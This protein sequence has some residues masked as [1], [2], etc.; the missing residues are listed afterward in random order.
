[1]VRQNLVAWANG[2]QLACQT[3]IDALLAQKLEE[4]LKPAKPSVREQ[5]L[6]GVFG[7]VGSQLVKGLVTL[8]EPSAAQ[9]AVIDAVRQVAATAGATRNRRASCVLMI[10]R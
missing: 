2:G 4:R 5:V 1:M 8:G 9:R 3:S 6:K 10:A 7:T